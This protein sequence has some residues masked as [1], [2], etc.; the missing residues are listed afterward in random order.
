MAK[1]SRNHVVDIIRGIAMLLVVLGHTMSR[2]VSEYSDSLIYQAIWTLQMP[3]F[4]IISGYVTRYSTPLTSGRDYMMFVK[5]R[6]LAYLLPW[7]VWTFIVRGLILD[8]P[9]F[10]DIKYLL[11]HMDSG[12]WFLITIWTI[13][14]VYGVSDLLSNLWFN[15]KRNNTLPHLLFCG[16]GFVGL[17]VV[18][19]FVGLGF[20]AIKLTLYYIPFFLLGYLYGTLQD[21]LMS[22]E[23]AN[24]IINVVVAV[25]LGIWLAAISRFDFFAGED[26]IMM[27]VRRF[28]VSLSGCVAI[29]G[30]VSAACYDRENKYFNWAG[31]HS[32][33]IYLTHYLFLSLA[34]SLNQPILSSMG[35]LF[36]VLVNFLLTMLLVVA[37]VMLVQSNRLLN[38]FLYAKQ[39]PKGLDN[40]S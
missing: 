6:T 38:F 5:K 15:N 14:M 13:S 33:E 8:Q 7:C 2:T 20:F 35:G 18:G 27:I 26:G 34:P 11:W 1:A 16:V 4:V 37:I 17:F 21:R 30:L 40:H 28:I 9:R 12:Y 3:L 19:C 22:K 31:V 24:S 23:K 36:S 32:L 39:V 29:I 25:S 10:L